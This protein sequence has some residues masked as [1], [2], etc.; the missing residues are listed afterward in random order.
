MRKVKPCVLSIEHRKAA[1]R[2]PGIRRLVAALAFAAG[3]LALAQVP[4]AAAQPQPFFYPSAPESFNATAASDAELALYGLPARPPQGSAAYSTWAARMA[5]ART[6]IPNPVAT[7]TAIQHTAAVK[8]ALPG[9]ANDTNSVNWSGALAS[10]VSGYFLA[11]ASFIDIAFQVPTIVPPKT[12]PG[13]QYG[14]YMTAI[15]GGMDGWYQFPGSNDVLQAGVNLTACYTGAAYQPWYEWW[16]SQCAQNG[17]TPPC[18]QTNLNL[19]VNP[20]DY[21]YIRVAYYTSGNNGY[22]GYAFV[23]DQS[24][25][26][27]VAVSF[28]EPPPINATTQYQ[29]ANAEWIVE[30]PSLSSYVDLLNYLGNAG[31]SGTEVYLGADYSD[32]TIY[33]GAWG[34]GYG[35]E[36]TITVV[37]MTCPPWNPTSACTNWGPYLSVGVYYPPNPNGGY[38]GIFAY[39]AGPVLQ[40]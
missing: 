29:G 19:A 27:Y 13:C 7:T 1:L 16:T 17:G 35:S 11:N 25:G 38:Y 36:S 22:N 21:M 9:I 6:R 5:N 3:Q 8:A 26:Q 23:S 24:S 39:P 2:L 28:N 32:N 4:P 14:P 31:P 15:W 34:I 30:R 20:G 37:D 18:Y 12:D 33:G 40:Q 10:G